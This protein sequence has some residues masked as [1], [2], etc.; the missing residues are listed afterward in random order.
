MSGRRVQVAVVGQ[1]ANQDDGA[2]HGER[3]PENNAGRPA[4]PER[5]CDDRA[6]R[7][8][9][10]AL[11]DR[12]RDRD[13]RTASSSSMWNCSPTPN[14]R[15]MTPT[16]ASCCGELGVRD[17]ARCVRP[18]EGAGEQVADDRREA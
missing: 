15:R 3:H 6:E 17:E 11:A 4:P 8:R 5:T 7:C 10:D 14:I 18:D 13:R 1:D 9:D 16:S 12:A 2:G